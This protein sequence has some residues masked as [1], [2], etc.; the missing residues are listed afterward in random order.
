MHG[1]VRL[2]EGMTMALIGVGIGL[3]GSFSRHAFSPAYF[4]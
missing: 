4:T 1:A 2:E 3:V